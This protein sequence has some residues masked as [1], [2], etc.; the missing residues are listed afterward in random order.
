VLVE[1]AFKG[2]QVA[3]YEA[4]GRIKSRVRPFLCF[5]SNARRR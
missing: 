1:R 4:A 5:G 3:L 2:L